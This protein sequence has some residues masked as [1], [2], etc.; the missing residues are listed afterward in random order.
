MI[1]RRQHA[2]YKV[3]FPSTFHGERVDGEGTVVDISTGGCRITSEASV[4]TGDY[5]GIAI[6]L[7]GE[8]AVLTV[9]LAAVRWSIGKEFGVEFIRIKA[10]HQERLRAIVAQLEQA[11]A[12]RQELASGSPDA[13]VAEEYPHQQ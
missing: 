12:R 7:S 11:S 13:V 5:I 1:N 6:Q 8:P 2:R 10:D 3:A 4:F 9:D